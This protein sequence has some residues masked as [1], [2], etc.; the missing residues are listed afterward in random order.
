MLKIQR[1]LIYGKKKHLIF[2][3]WQRRALQLVT[4]ISSFSRI[5]KSI[6]RNYAWHLLNVCSLELVNSSFEIINIRCSCRS[7][8]FFK[9]I[10][11][12]CSRWGVYGFNITGWRNKGIYLVKCF[13][14]C[15][16]FTSEPVLSIESGRLVHVLLDD[17]STA[18]CFM[19]NSY[20]IDR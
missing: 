20:L 4:N 3:H 11:I 9:I 16:S 2:F 19:Q 8:S 7:N 17:M 10:N 5:L 18:R 13:P 6:S 1:H 12:R 14:V 15:F